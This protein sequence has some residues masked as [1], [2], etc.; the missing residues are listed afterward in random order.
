MA[1]PRGS[2]TIAKPRI[3]F[4]QRVCSVLLILNRKIF[5]VAAYLAAAHL[6]RFGIA[7][8]ARVQDFRIK[9]TGC[10]QLLHILESGKLERLLEHRMSGMDSPSMASKSRKC[11]AGEARRASY[12]IRVK[13]LRPENSSIQS[14][15]VFTMARTP[16]LLSRSI[17]LTFFCLSSTGALG[18]RLVI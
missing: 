12:R 1:G 8:V 14:F 9:C 4:S 7:H 13:L 18:S 17:S 15:I 3:E 16:N 5:P 6:E 10:L 2:E 11:S